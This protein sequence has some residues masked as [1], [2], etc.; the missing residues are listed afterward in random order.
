MGLDP[1]RMDRPQ[2][3]ENPPRLWDLSAKPT[4]PLLANMGVAVVGFLLIATD[5]IAS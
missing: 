3:S 1:A 2:L 4:A 5:I